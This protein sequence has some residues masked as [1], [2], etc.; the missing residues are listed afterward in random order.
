MISLPIDL[1]LVAALAVTSWRTGR[2]YRELRRLRS[3]DSAF[4]ALLG[5]SDAALNR[6]AHA[7]ITLKSEG[8]RTLAA[9]EQRISEAGRIEARLAD[10]AAY[11]ALG[12]AEPDLGTVWLGR[13]PSRLAP[14]SSRNP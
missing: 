13:A 4:R 11:A 6:A 7:V 12:P 9:L 14:A 2:M 3:E 5:E 1:V 8:V 10:A